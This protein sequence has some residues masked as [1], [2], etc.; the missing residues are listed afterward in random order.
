MDQ[1]KVLISLVLAAQ[2]GILIRIEMLLPAYTISIGG[3]LAILGLMFSGEKIMSCIIRLPSGYYADKYGRKTPLLV[4]HALKSIASL[5]MGF[6]SQLY[7]LFLGMILR[8]LALGLGNSSYFSLIGE[9]SQKE[10]FGLTFGLEH[11]ANVLTLAFSS[12]ITGII[13]DRCGLKIPIFI[14]SILFFI[15]FIIVFFLV[16]ERQSLDKNKKIEN[17]TNKKIS[18]DSFKIILKNRNY[19]YTSVAFF[20]LSFSQ[21]VFLPFYTVYVV[22]TLGFSFSQFGLIMFISNLFG[23]ISSIY[24]GFLVDKFGSKKILLGVG[25]FRTTMYLLL[26]FTKNI[27]QVA[28]LYFIRGI[29]YANPPRNTMLMKITQSDFRTKVFSA[30]DLT[31]DLGQAIGTICLGIIAEILSL[32]IAFLVMGI[33]SILYIVFITKIK[34]E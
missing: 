18:K 8:G 4:S 32:Q 17:I 29:F 21:S 3:N 31:R 34:I 23:F 15:S 5:I 27:Y 11:A 19:M 9:T 2:I 26:P 24:T 13:L 12:L 10:K 33:S 28:F 25:F 20:L 6:S 30:I 7:S 1:K 16:E 14:S 22:D